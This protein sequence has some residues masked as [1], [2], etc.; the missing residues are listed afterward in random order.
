MLLNDKF[1]PKDCKKKITYSGSIIISRTKSF[2]I[3]GPYLVLQLML[4]DYLENYGEVEDINDS[5]WKMFR[6]SIN[7]G[8]DLP[9]SLPNPL[10]IV[11]C[12][13]S[14]KQILKKVNCAYVFKSQQQNISHLLFLDD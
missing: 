9:I 3:L 8:R 11:Q 1:L 5:L 7:K 14:L 13:I 6:D 2:N 10:I 4:S 12:M